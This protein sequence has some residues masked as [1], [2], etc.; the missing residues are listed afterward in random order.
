I[1][2][3]DDQGHYDSVFSPSTNL[4]KFAVT[5]ASV[6]F[7]QLCVSS[8]LFNYCSPIGGDLD[9]SYEIPT[10]PLVLTWAGIPQLAGT[11]TGYGWVPYPR[12]TTDLLDRDHQNADPTHWTAWGL[13][14]NSTN[15]GP[16]QAGSLHVLYAQ[17]RDN[18]DHVSTLKLRLTAIGPT[19]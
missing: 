3:V 19:H 11:L 14:N 2:A 15:V 12:D 6:G 18:V 10:N 16:F 7:P 4:L 9:L 8:S 5:E 17:A 13:T 1:T